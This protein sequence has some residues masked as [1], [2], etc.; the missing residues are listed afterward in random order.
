[1]GRRQTPVQTRR[2]GTGA[3]WLPDPVTSDS[4]SNGAI[5]VSSPSEDLV[6][7]RSAAR[8]VIRG[9]DFTA[10]V[11]EEF[12]AQP[13]KWLLTL[14]QR[15]SRCNAVVVILAHCYGTVVGR[16]ECPLANGR[17]SVTEIEIELAIEARRSILYFE[18]APDGPE[19]KWPGPREC[20]RLCE[21]SSSAEV[22]SIQHGMRQLRRLKERLSTWH[23]AK[24]TTPES[25]QTEVAKALV[26]LRRE[27][28]FGT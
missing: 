23:Y 6:A 3:T 4:Y 8:D 24:F 9:C 15:I 26:R 19:F 12:G 14:P 25:L 7:Y 20:H 2:H 11:F 17:R 18:V 13:H 5:F 21:D 22:K 10:V 27:Q 16:G 28:G 1:M